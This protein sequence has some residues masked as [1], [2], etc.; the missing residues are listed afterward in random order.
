MQEA[1]STFK[2]R[3]LKRIAACTCQCD[4]A[5]CPSPAVSLPPSLACLKAAEAGYWALAR[6]AFERGLELDPQHP[7]LSDKLLQLLLHVG[8]GG[9][10]AAVAAALLRTTP[11][12]ACAAA[13]L[14][15]QRGGHT[16]PTLRSGL[17]QLAPIDAVAGAAAA[18]SA[19]QA[20]HQ[21]LERPRTL[22]Q[23]SWQQLLHHSL[24]FL[25]ANKL[26]ESGAAHAS[27]P[28]AAAAA[29]AGE[30]GTA[31]RGHKQVASL[32]RFTYK[33]PYAQPT[34]QAAA[35]AAAPAA[36]HVQADQ[37]F[38]GGADVP[39][40]GGAAA[41]TPAAQPEQCSNLP[42]AEAMAAA[43]AAGGAL[44]AT[45]ELAAAAGSREGGAEATPLPS[46]AA[47]SPAPADPGSS[48]L[49]AA[50]AV[51]G[52]GGQQTPQ[53]AA[54]EATEEQQVW[55][56]PG[57]RASSGAKK[58]EARATRSRCGSSPDSPRLASSC[59]VLCCAVRYHA[60]CC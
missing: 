21:H 60:C 39:A 35:G 33:R 44:A 9:A 14:T 30:P 20:R 17:L 42:A 41:S 40:A 34:Q 8:D 18:A 38:P 31:D 3:H 2:L 51:A 54:P 10:A 55:R 27:T 36:A 53:V 25:A 32:V 58:G 22:D 57:G 26:P 29:A 49:A 1:R 12:H 47:A 16:L 37:Q 11:R 24:L 46:L 7:T 15:A 23:P 28:T 59:A 5:A 6:N 48:G 45:G 56:R 19:R 4:P 13:V 50:V 52:N 43:D